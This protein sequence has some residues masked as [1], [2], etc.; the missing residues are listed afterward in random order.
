MPTTESPQTDWLSR[1]QRYRKLM[2]G[3]IL[4]AVAVSILLRNFDY[5]LAGEAV[6]W[7]GLVSYG[8]IW[9]G[10][11]VQVM[12]ERDW[13]L[14]RRASMTAIQLAGAVLIVGA[15]TARLLPLLTD[16]TVPVIVSGALYGYVGLFVA[17]G[18][19]YLW[20]RYRL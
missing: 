15:S 5:H 11:D 10:T 7:L 3:S 17:F 18:V 19:A 20:H 2:I 14:E 1:R 8:V 12:D 13:E 16:Y 6:L 9:K 4:G